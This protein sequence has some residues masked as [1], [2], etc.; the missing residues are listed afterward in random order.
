MSKQL[1]KGILKKKSLGI[2]SLAVL[3]DPDYLKLKNLEQTLALSQKQGVD[4]FFLGG[5]LILQDRMDETIKLIREMTNIPIVLFPGNSQ[6]IH[7]GADAILLLSLISGRNPDYLI[8]KHV[9]SAMRLK[10]SQ[11]EV[12]STA[13][14]L[15]DGAQANTAAYISQTQPIPANKPD[16]ALATAMA[17]E[18]LNMQLLYLDAGSGARKP[19][20]ETMIQ[21]LSA[22]IRLPILVG[23]GIRDG[24]TVYNILQA[25]ADLIV[26]GNLL[27]ED[28]KQLKTI[29]E[30]VKNHSPLQ[31]KKS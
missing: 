2:K 23:G 24:E 30:L 19:V 28:P 13:Y 8:G 27:E 11:L 1:L 25:G 7:P 15:I 10:A 14:L 6:Q 26:V 22:H 18:L 16:I 20:P 4:Y 12:I 3:I 5:S 21:K 17:G 29:A 9:E 31:V